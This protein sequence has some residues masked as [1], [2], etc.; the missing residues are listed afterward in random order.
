MSNFKL[1]VILTKK[2]DQLGTVTTKPGTKAEYN[3]LKLHGWSEQKT[4]P[5]TGQS[6]KKEKK[7]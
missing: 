6:Q 1:G 4:K 7:D 5:A 3:N 2:D